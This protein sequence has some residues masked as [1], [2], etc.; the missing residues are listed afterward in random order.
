MGLLIRTNRDKAIDAAARYV[1][2]LQRRFGSRGDLILAA[3]NAGEATVEAFRAG[4]T[5]VLPNNNVINPR[6][7]RTGGIPP[8][9]ET[10]NYVARGAVVYRNIAQTTF[11]ASNWIE[12]SAQK[13]QQTKTRLRDSICQDSVYSLT[14]PTDLNARPSTKST[15]VIQTNS[16]YAN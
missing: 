12:D 3:Y 4:K 6:G 11:S 13:L 5:L 7:L 10:R 14:N 16:F 9:E 2:D 8:Y 1:R 15:P